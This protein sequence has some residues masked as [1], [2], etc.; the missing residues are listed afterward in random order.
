M[1]TEKTQLVIIDEWSSNRMQSDLAKTV[2]QGGWMVT[3]VK[4]G[5]PRCVNNNSPFYITTNNVP[6]FRKEDENVKRRI[7]IFQTTSLPNTIPGIDSWIFDHAMD[8]IAWTAEEIHQHRDL[9]CHEELWYE[10]CEN[11][12][13]A[14]RDRESLWKRHEIDQI[15]KAD[16]Q[17]LC[18]K[19][20]TKVDEHDEGKIRE[21][22]EDNSEENPNESENS[23]MEMERSPS[24]T[25]G[26]TNAKHVDT[27]QD[28]GEEM[29]DTEENINESENSVMDMERS[30]SVCKRGTSAKGEQNGSEQMRD[31]EENMTSRTDMQPPPSVSVNNKDKANSAIAR[32]DYNT[33][34]TRYSSFT[35]PAGWVLNDEEY[36]DKVANYIE[37]S[38]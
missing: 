16:M 14:S 15:T 1:I 12:P 9:I 22:I 5:P 27:E 10:N 2:L 35:P 37:C 29:R 25:E 36:V 7:R 31:S 23:D 13:V 33:L 24:V 8:C 28:R 32:N 21:R 20:T 3:S 19:E 6:D 26:G 11:A 17:P 30:P 38:L 18:H 4:H 34:T